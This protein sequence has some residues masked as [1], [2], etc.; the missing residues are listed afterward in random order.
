MRPKRVPLSPSHSQSLSM[1]APLGFVLLKR[2]FVVVH[3]LRG[4]LREHLPRWLEATANYGGN[5]FAVPVLCNIKLVFVRI[6]LR[7]NAMRPNQENNHVGVLLQLARVL[8]V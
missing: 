8:Q 1:S 4:F 6:S 3:V 2:R 7:I 5:C